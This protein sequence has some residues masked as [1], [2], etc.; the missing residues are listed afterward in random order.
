MGII[1]STL[2]FALRSY[3]A[4][5]AL[6]CSF[7][8]L[9]AATS[10]EDGALKQLEQQRLLRQ[11]TVLAFLALWERTFESIISWAPFYSAVKLLAH[12]AAVVPGADGAGLLFSGVLKPALL[13]AG[14]RLS[15]RAA[16]LLVCALGA[17]STRAAALA[18]TPAE[19]AAWAAALRKQRQRAAEELLA[20]GEPEAELRGEEELT[21]EERATEVGVQPLALV[22]SP[23]LRARRRRVE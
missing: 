18:R 23:V 3:G 21:E 9:R 11:W 4:A 16:P 20:R 8:S 12:L 7:R 13:L 6:L 19:A 1:S 15:A 22:D 2:F 17:A 5:H 14:A 10:P